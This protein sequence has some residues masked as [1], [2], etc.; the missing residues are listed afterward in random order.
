LITVA[1]AAMCVS[2]NFPPVSSPFLFCCTCC[3]GF[4]IFFSGSLILTMPKRRSV[5]APP[6]VTTQRNQSDIALTWWAEKRDALRQLEEEKER[7]ASEVAFLQAEKQRLSAEVD[8]LNQQIEKDQSLI[9]DVQSR[10]SDAEPILREAENFGGLTKIIDKDS[11]ANAIGRFLLSLL[12]IIMKRTHPI[13]RLRAVCDAIF[14][15]A[16]FGVAV[17]KTVLSEVYKKYIFEEHRSKFAPW[18]VLRAIDLSS[19]G[20][21]NFNGI[22][23]LRTVE[24]LDP[25][26]R[27]ILPARSTIQKASHELHELGQQHIPFHRK[28]CSVV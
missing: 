23:T 21:L 15:L 18:R 24:E 4:Y 8:S 22:E 7:F 27:G 26:Q 28:Q 20:G 2:L 1:L 13:T 6:V 19:V 16:I 12:A 9:R 11:R 14:G 17:T 10:L 3:Y 5:D 25:Y